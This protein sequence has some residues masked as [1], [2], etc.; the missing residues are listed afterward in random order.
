MPH[1]DFAYTGPKLTLR[2]LQDVPVADAKAE[3]IQELLGGALF[4]ALYKWMV[5]SGPVYLLPTGRNTQGL[6][7]PQGLAMAWRDTV[8]SS[9]STLS[10]DLCAGPVSSFLVVSDP[11]AAKHVLRSTDN[12]NR[13]I[14]VKGLVQEVICHLITICLGS[15]IFISGETICYESMPTNG[16]S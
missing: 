5:E 3:D 14:Y 13:P 12:P 1:Q 6:T 11:A 16:P 8:T 15:K 2:C 10:K 7:C 4:K 9:L